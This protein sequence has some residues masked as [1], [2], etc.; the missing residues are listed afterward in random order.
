MQSCIKAE[1]DAVIIWGLTY[2][3]STLGGGGES[4]KSRQ[5]EQGNVNSVIYKGREGTKIS[6]FFADVI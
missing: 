2:I 5:K 1:E 4:A 6:D 3:T